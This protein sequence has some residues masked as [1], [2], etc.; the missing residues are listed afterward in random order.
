MNNS[1]KTLLLSAVGA[2]SLFV[3]STNVNAATTHKV[4]KNDTVWGLSQKFNVSV[5]SIERLNHIDMNSHL[6]TVGQ[7]IKVPVTANVKTTPAKSTA[8]A[9]AV[10]S[11]TVRAGDSLYTI[12]Q[13]HG[14]SVDSLRQANS[15]NGS[16]LQIGQKL[17][18]NN[19]SVKTSNVRSQQSST[20]QTQARDTVSQGQAQQVQPKVSTNSEAVTA[21]SQVNSNKTSSYNAASETQTANTQ[22]PVNSQRSTAGQAQAQPKSN[23]VNSSA[24]SQNTSTYSSAVSYANSFLGSSYVYGGTSPAGFDCS[25]FTQ[26]VYSKYGKTL[27]RTSQAQANAG[28][29]ISTSQAQPGD[30]II[31]NGGGH[32]GIATGNGNFI[33][34]ENP[35]DGVASSNVKYWG[36][37]YAVRLK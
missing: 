21:Q 14:V 30:L 19:S 34:A 2:A 5:K 32:V 10:S 16:A 23:Y 37:S 36:P 1:T 13:A 9:A 3:A 29:R 11:Y 18:I 31:T 28:T 6:I 26:Y 4:V 7:D 25:G 20:T 15:L 35:R 12:A 27:P 22:T 17:L 33:S 8:P 24:R